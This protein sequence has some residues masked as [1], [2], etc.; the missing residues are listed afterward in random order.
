VET[1]RVILFHVIKTNYIY[2]L[3]HNYKFFKAKAK[4]KRAILLL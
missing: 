2:N 4:I 1:L 3:K